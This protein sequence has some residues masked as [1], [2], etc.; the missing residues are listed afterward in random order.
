MLKQGLL[1]YLTFCHC[2]ERICSLDTLELKLSSGVCSI[3]LSIKKTLG[4]LRDFCG[5]FILCIGL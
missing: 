4:G 3:T 1:F 5:N 2:I